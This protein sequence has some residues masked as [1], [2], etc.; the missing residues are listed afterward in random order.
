MV[1]PD[2]A[3]ANSVYTVVRNDGVETI[4]PAVWTALGGKVEVTI[5]PDT[6]TL[7][8]RVDAGRNLI[9]AAPYRL[10]LTSGGGR[11]YSTLR[12][13]GT[14]LS[15]TKTALRLRTPIPAYLTDQDIASST[16]HI[17]CRTYA[18]AR[19][20]L[21]AQANACSMAVGNL[22]A[23]VA[24]LPA[25]FGERA[26]AIVKRPHANYRIRTASTNSQSTTFDAD[27]H[28]TIDDVTEGWEGAGLMT[29][30]EVNAV[31]ED[32]RI[33]SFNGSP[34]RTEN[35]APPA[36]PTLSGYGAGEYGDGPY[37]G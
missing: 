15:Y 34:L 36:L 11:D 14:G 7:R 31:W 26:G 19:R 13:V 35:P 23:E 9:D 10:A 25:P 21:R 27:L 28:T 37:G 16:D 32:Y 33:R 22:S 17:F 1:G 30:D 8:I 5:L 4:D 20:Q 6:Q 18:Q 2:Y 12:I 3:G 29:I 24:S